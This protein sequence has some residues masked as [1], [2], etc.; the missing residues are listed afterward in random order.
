M[1]LD[2]EG[3]EI[4][5]LKSIDFNNININYLCVEMINHNEQSIEKGKQIHSYL[6]LNEYQLVKQLGFNFIYKKK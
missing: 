5:V 6:T 4:E 2:V 1:N 3:H